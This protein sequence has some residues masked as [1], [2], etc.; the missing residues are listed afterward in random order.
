MQDVVLFDIT[1]NYSQD[2]ILECAIISTL[3]KLTTYLESIK[4]YLQIFG[5]PVMSNL[6]VLS[7]FPRVLA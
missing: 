3:V 7:S 4:I 6:T 1:E 2:R 5:L